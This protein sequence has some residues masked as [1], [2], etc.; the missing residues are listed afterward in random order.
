VD[1]TEKQSKEDKRTN[2]HKQHNIDETHTQR[3]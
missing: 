2:D 1:Q 3:P